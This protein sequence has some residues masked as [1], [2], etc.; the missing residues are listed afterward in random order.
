MNSQRDK[1]LETFNSID[2]HQIR[3]HPNILIA[4]TFWEPERYC[5]ASTCYK[6][7]RTI[8]DLIDDHKAANKLIAPDE[9]NAFVA[10][11]NEWLKTFE[12]IK[13]IHPLL[14]PRYQLSL[15][16]IFELYLLVFERINIEKGTFTSEELNPCPEETKQRVYETIMKF[17]P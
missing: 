17:N 13:K 4:A 8:D 2:F 6:F 14:E 9:R 1:F 7:M 12:I 11:V 16:I 15:E 3:D 5:A 10:N